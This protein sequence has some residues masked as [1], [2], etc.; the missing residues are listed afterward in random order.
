MLLKHKIPIL[1]YDTDTI[2]VLGNSYGYSFPNKAV[3]AFLGEDIEN[4][5]LKNNCE[6]INE[7]DT[8]TK[9]IKIYKTIYKKQEI[10]LC[11]APLGASAATQLLEFLIG[12]GVNKVIAV[13]SCGALVD[14]PENKFLLPALAL[15]DE[16]TSYHYL[17]AKRYVKINQKALN[18]LKETFE[19]LNIEYQICKTWTTDG[20][21]RET[22]ELIRHR[23]S[24]G[25]QVVE[26]E[27]SALAA[28]CEFRQITF[29]SILFTADS[30]ANHKNYDKREW[31]VKASKK[32]L[33]IALE[34]I[35]NL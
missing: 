28:C 13:G 17:P 30:L 2:S 12:A 34:A 3:F 33:N 29:G 26:M 27:C 11:Q 1:E 32:V 23:I 9:P 24:E 14:L 4:Y 21:Y 15:R 31:G 5:A 6:Q 10:T 22:S 20:F 7:F 19:I 16:G 35:C 18:V 25:C 8:I